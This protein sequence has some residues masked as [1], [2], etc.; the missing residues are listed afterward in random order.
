[1]AERLERLLGKRRAVR[2][3]T[4]RLSQ[5]IET[6]VSKEDPVV[7]RLCELLAVL[8]AKEE[9]LLEL[10]PEIEEHT[11]AEDLENEVVDAEEYGQRVISA[12]ARVRRVMQ[13]VRENTDRRPRD[14]APARRGQTVKL[15]ELIINKFSGDISLWQDFWNQFET[16]I[17]RNDALSKTEKFNYLKTYVAGAASKA[18]AG[19][20]LTDS[21]YDH[22]IDLLQN[23]FGRKD[24]LIDAHVTKSSNLCPVKKS[25]DECEV[26]IRSFESLG[27]ASEAY[28]SLLCP[29]LL[30]M[31]PEDIALQYSRQ[32]GS[33]DEWKV[34]EVMEFLQ[35]EILSGERTTPLIKSEAYSKILQSQ[36]VLYCVCGGRHHSTVCEK[37]ETTASD[38]DDKDDVVSSFASHSVKMQSDKQNTVLLQTV[39]AWAEGPGGRKSIRCSLDGGSQ[40]SFISENTVRALKLPVTKQETFTLHTFGS[41]APATSRRDIVN[42]GNSAKHLEQR[43]ESGSGGSRNSTSVHCCD[44]D[45][46]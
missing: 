11:D 42:E 23:R 28:G 8:S 9:T 15:P 43:S 45:S 6:E 22:A 24:L 44:E 29:V 41:T 16:A 12:K 27:V 38:V 14:A 32:R 33:S 37:G 35:N 40:R 46:R 4:T 30:R 7:D 20:M 18:I 21:N 1:M 19:L 10:D 26:Q 31:I 39:R 17:H 2:G 3:S 25:Y 5:D 13:R 34:S 36:S